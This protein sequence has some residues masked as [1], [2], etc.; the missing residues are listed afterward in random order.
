MNEESNYHQITVLIIDASAM[1][2]TLTQATLNDGE[3]MDPRP[4]IGSP[5]SPGDTFSA[6]NKALAPQGNLGANL[7]FEMASGANLVVY[8]NWNFGSGPSA[9]ALSN[10]SQVDVE[11]TLANPQSNNPSLTVTIRDQNS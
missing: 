4:K 7:Q 5:I 2:L 6:A 1:T 3:W 10:S 11:Y 8:W 9:N